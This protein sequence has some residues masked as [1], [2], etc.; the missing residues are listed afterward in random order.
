M[1]SDNGV[2]IAELDQKRVF[3]PFFTTKLGQGGSGLGM[4][5]VYNIT[6]GILGGTIRLESELARGTRIVLVLPL[7][8][9]E[10]AL[11][12]NA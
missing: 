7:R 5:I 9:P 12:A 6:T 2:G 4:H 1:F 10:I 8:A 11:D 3:D